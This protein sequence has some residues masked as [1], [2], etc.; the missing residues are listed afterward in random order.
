[1][2]LDQAYNLVGFEVVHV[3]TVIITVKRILK[4]LN[5]NKNKK[6]T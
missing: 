1:M 4:K 6:L 5:K 3:L 2:K